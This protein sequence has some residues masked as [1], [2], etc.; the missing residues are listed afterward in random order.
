MTVDRKGNLMAN[1]AA[2]AMLEAI[3]VSLDL[4]NNIGSRV[5]FG[6]SDRLPSCFAV[7]ELAVASISAA[8]AAVSELA[9]LVSSA[10]PVSVSYRLA[11]LWF[12]WSIRP[13]GWDMPNPWDAIAG[14]YQAQDGWIK[15]HTNAPHH[16]AAALAVLGCD[17]D[18][19]AVADA[20]ATWSADTLEAAIVSAGG[21][22]ARLRTADEWAKHPQGRAVAAEPLIMWDG[23]CGQTTPDWCPLP[24]RPLSGLRVLDLTRVLA[25]PVATR[26][27]AGFGADVLR[28]DPPE[29]DE[30]GVIPEVTL[31]KRCARLDLKTTAG[32]DVFIE[33]LR[34]A[35]ILV[36]G[37]RSDAL[38]QIGLGASAREMIRPG[39]IDISLDAYGHSGPWAKRRG[40][41]SLVQFSSGIAAEG[42]AW[43]NAEAPV[44]LPVQALD[45]ATGY[46]LA[47]AA[48]RGVIARTMGSGATRA[49]LSLAR[50]AKLLSDYRSDPSTD[51]LVASKDDDFD[52]LLEQTDWGAAHRLHPPTEIDG[53]PML[54]A[55]PATKLG[56]STAEWLE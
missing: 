31:G 30:P 24:S 18:R 23:S 42:M 32:R 8:A 46:L 12:G 53:I 45:H 38:E 9:G 16:R 25:G 13:E 51:A 5:A 29:W 11:S 10:P 34:G 22:A 43:R 2:H 37:Y 15:L 1:D 44:S 56:S 49:R 4:H 36:H 7:S 17:P 20:V 35:D 27:L 19:E 52:A 47:A 26:F 6:G 41:D 40:F 39:L 28:I 33:L 14:D 55:R 54:W 50:T 48:V 3:L 21:C